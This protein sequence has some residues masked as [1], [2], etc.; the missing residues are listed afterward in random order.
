M[1]GLVGTVFSGIANIGKTIIKGR[2]V[3]KG[4]QEQ[5][6]IREDGQFNS[7][8]KF[9]PDG[10]L[11]K[12]IR[13]LLTLAIAAPVLVIAIA[14]A[15][16]V[17]IALYPVI[18]GTT[19]VAVGIATIAPIFGLFDALSQ[20]YFNMFMTVLVFWFGGRM[21]KYHINSSET[22]HVITQN[23]NK[24]ANEGGWDTNVPNPPLSKLQTFRKNRGER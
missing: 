9:K 15:I 20:N 8:R 6:E 17:G 5:R 2:K 23:G 19:T 18:L 11:A 3:F 22:K 16:L 24:T 7:A 21:H 1:L 4:D 10:W 13:P 12:Q 14:I